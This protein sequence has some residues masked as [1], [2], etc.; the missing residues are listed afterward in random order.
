MILVYISNHLFWTSLG[1]GVVCGIL[2]GCRCDGGFIVKAVKIAS[3]LLKFFDPFL[4]LIDTIGQHK[5]RSGLIEIE[6]GQRT[7]AYLGDHHMAVKGAGP[8]GCVRPLNVGSY[9]GDHRRP[10][11]HVGHEMTIHLE[12]GEY[13]LHSH[14]VGVKAYNVYMKPCCPLINSV[15][16]G[17]A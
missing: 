10:E 16:T 6:K 17:S 7:H 9:L 1:L 15:R 4:G 12:Y 8:S 11:S 2:G 3:G 5:N 13:G 14:K